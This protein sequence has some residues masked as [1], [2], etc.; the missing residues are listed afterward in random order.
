MPTDGVNVDTFP[1]TFE[2][3]VLELPVKELVIGTALTLA[4]TRLP[5]ASRPTTWH[6]GVVPMV[7]VDAFPPTFDTRELALLVNELVIG[8]AFTLA[9]TRL[10]FVSRPTTWHI[11]VVPMVTVD[12]FPPTFD[13]RELA[14]LVN[15]FVV[16]A[17]PAT[18]KAP[19]LLKPNV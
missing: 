18:T 19:L 10:P 11:G 5:V 14:L 2:T 3:R 1:P 4:L 12:A 8:T 17:L 15:E 6:I 7:T 13:T 16:G 9:L